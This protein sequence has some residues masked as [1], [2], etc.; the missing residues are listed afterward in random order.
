M[1]PALARPTCRRNIAFL[2]LSL[3]GLLDFILRVLMG[4]ALR[5]TLVHAQVAVGLQAA[6]PVDKLLALA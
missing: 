6:R 5:L 3:E 1:S 2:L 4:R